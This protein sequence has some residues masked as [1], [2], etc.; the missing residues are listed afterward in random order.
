MLL[1]QMMI[2]KMIEDF[3]GLLKIKSIGGMQ[4]ASELYPYGENVFQVLDYM[5]NLALSDGFEIKEYDGHALAIILG[6]GE[7]RI[8]VVCHLDVVHEGI[9]WTH[10]PFGAKQ[11]GDI[12]YG[13]GTQDDKGP[14]M[15]AYTA[16][17]DIKL[18]LELGQ[19][20]PLQREL[21]L[22]FGCD[23]ERT[24]NDIKY[25]IAK[26]GEPTFAFTPDGY[27]PLSIGE[28]G[29]LMWALKG[30]ASGV[31]L[32]LS[33]GVQCNVIPPV[34]EATLKDINI[35]TLRDCLERENTVYTLTQ[36]GSELKLSVKGKAAHASKPELGDNA[37]L[38][39]LKGV[40]QAWGDSLAMMLFNTFADSYGVAADMA[41]ES[42]TMGKL[43]LNLGV[44]RI[45]DGE[46]YAEVDCRYPMEADS[47]KLTQILS[48]QLHGIS[49][50]LD[51]DAKP[52]MNDVR[53][54][55]IQILLKN[56]RTWSKDEVSEPLI[57]GG[58]SYSKV[59]RHCVAFGP[60]RQG[61]VS[62]AHQ[63]DEC[64]DVN[65]MEKLLSLYTQTMID[66]TTQ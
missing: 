59:I 56:Y 38:R 19:L 42:E 36:D 21:R 39:L 45:K 12:I 24:M 8:D 58:V 1:K 9:G 37:T 20:K 7:E 61:E 53:D 17:K 33:G 49:V 25:Y 15:I 4:A 41:T 10:E 16:M 30:K 23:E 54:P 66:L 2:R 64:I 6:S 26:D 13:R 14:A 63:A 22:V 3:K 43:T 65:E 50:S 57:S 28:K 52:I 51:Y 11:I 55:F 62:L 60:H 47:A 35:E 40:A 18:G 44:L 27:F 48:N 31:I 29:A 46:L 5:K 34:A 32:S